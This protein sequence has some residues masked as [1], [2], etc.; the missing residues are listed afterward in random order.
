MELAGEAGFER[1]CTSEVGRLLSTLAASL[2]HAVVAEL[3]TGYG[4]GAS[5]IASTLPASSRLIT[6]EVDPIRARAASELFAGAPNVTVIHGDWSEILPHGPFGFLFADATGAKQERVDRLLNM[7]TIGGMLLIDDLTPEELWPD[8]WRGK[9]D[10]VREVWLNDER[11]AASEIRVSPAA[12]VILAT[13][14]R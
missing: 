12:A 2:H 13:R 1:S 14:L 8:E 10:P 11:V 6:I 4:V 3:G 7:L 9:P 5:W